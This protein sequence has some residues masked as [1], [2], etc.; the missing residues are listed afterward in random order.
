MKM[1]FLSKCAMRIM[2]IVDLY[3]GSSGKLF[4]PTSSFLKNDH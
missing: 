3:I 2:K 1:A 4:L